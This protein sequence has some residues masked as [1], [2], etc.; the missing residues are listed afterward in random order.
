MVEE[1]IAELRR[2]HAIEAQS[3][4]PPVRSTIG[5]VVGG[6]KTAGAVVTMV[7]GRV[8]WTVAKAV[9]PE[10]SNT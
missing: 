7:R 8:R 10:G 1:A 4:A 9:T 5:I 3:G 6:G 2:K